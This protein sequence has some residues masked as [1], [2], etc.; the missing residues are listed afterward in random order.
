MDVLKCMQEEGADE[1][2][3]CK[4]FLD[5]YKEC[6]HHRKYWERRMRVEQER[7]RQREAGGEEGAAVVKGHH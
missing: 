3:K 2:A 5:D 4:P 6:L 1:P 7:R